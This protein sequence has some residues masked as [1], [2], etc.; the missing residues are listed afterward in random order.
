[1]N[2]SEIRTLRIIE[3]ERTSPRFG[4]RLLP[5][6]M[7]GIRHRT[8]VKVLAAGLVQQQEGCWFQLTEEGTQC[9]RLIDDRHR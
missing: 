6:E 5:G 9:L 1:M 3:T 4:V 8:L 2:K 7:H